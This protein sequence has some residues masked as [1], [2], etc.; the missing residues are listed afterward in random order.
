MD[1]ENLIKTGKF[2]IEFLQSDSFKPLELIE[3]ISLLSDSGGEVLES[4]IAYWNES[5]RSEK[6]LDINH[7]ILISRGWDEIVPQEQLLHFLPEEKL[8]INKD[9][10]RNKL[11]GVDLTKISSQTEKSLMESLVNDSIGL[12]RNDVLL[13]YNLLKI[14]Q[15]SLKSKK[16]GSK[17]EILDQNSRYIFNL[18]CDGFNIRDLAE[19]DS[20]QIIKK[21]ITRSKVN[22]QVLSLAVGR[23]YD[24][25]YNFL[26]EFISMFITRR[27]DNEEELLR[28]MG[29]YILFNGAK[30]DELDKLGLKANDIAFI[31]DRIGRVRSVYYVLILFIHTFNLLICAQVFE[32]SSKYYESDTVQQEKLRKLYLADSRRKLLL[33]NALNIATRKVS[34]YKSESA[35]ILNSFKR[36]TSKIK[37]FVTNEDLFSSDYRG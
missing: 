34:S 24:K 13:Y 2:V 36:Y 7:P 25:F 11:D 29:L 20:I 3:R 32:I 9:I 1:N 8:L 18:V 6:K 10:F 31:T 21:V 12:S 5:S 23:E 17:E 30:E 35:E 37:C 26:K 22:P 16:S 27:G 19:D 15:I 33:N 28:L 14:N 4:L